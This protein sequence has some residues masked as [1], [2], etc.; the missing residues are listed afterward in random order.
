MD[1]CSVWFKRA[2]FLALFLVIG[3]AGPMRVFAQVLVQ[4]NNL[5]ESLYYLYQHQTYDGGL[6]EQSLASSDDIESAWG[7]IAFSSLGYDPSLVAHTNSGSLLD[8]T[9]NKAC[10][11]TSFT[12]IERTILVVSAA[13][14]DPALFGGCELT[15]KISTE[16]NF[17]TGMIGP[18]LISTIYGV[19]VYYDL[20]WPV[21]MESIEF[22]KQSQQQSDGGWAGYPGS[23]ADSN[24]SA[25]ALIALA[26][27]GLDSSDQNIQNGMQFLKGL[28]DDSGGIRNDKSEYST[29]QDSWSDA[30]TLMAI[31]A[32][33]ESPTDDFWMNGDKSILDGLSLLR[34][35]DGSYIYASWGDTVP[36]WTTSLVVLGLSGQQFPVVKVLLGKYDNSETLATQPVVQDP[37]STSSSPSVVTAVASSTP[38]ATT[39][40]ATVETGTMTPIATASATSA[41]VAPVVATPDSP[42]GSVKLSNQPAQKVLGATAES[43]GI[44][45][46]LIII[47]ILCGL[48]VG[49]LIARIYRNKK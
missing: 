6:T 41:S 3:F 19:F 22:I 32:L 29:E 31:T 49:Y 45:W 34:Q 20:G 1:K 46:I 26:D 21:P 37:T 15:S 44:N 7:S 35:T 24:T 33:K 11:Y 47:L 40:V 10:N 9:K 8:A 18:D 13:R 28:Q 38:S 25:Q 16:T 5:E 12:D 43:K 27:A 4:Q 39:A 17:E 23:S 36:V 42:T 14:L 48:G 30:Y 2:V